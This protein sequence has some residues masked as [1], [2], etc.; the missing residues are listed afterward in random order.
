MPKCFNLTASA[1]GCFRSAF[2]C[3]GLRSTITDLGDGTTIHCWVPKSPKPTKP[4]VVLIHGFGADAVWQWFEAVKILTPHFNVY[5]PDL[6][7]FGESHTTRPDR[8]EAFQAQCVK[9]VMEAKS[10]EKMRLVGMSYG[11]FVAY[12]MA[13][14]FED[15]VEKVVIICS[16]VCLEER[17]I[18]DGMFPVNNVDD[19][20]SILLPQTPEAFRKL[21]R[22][23]FVKPPKPLPSCLINDF[24]QE[25][26]LDF[27]EEKRDL[28]RAIPLD[29]KLAD[30]PKIPQPTLILWGDKDQVFPV[31]L[32]RRLKGHLGENAEL[33]ILEGT[34]HACA[35]EKSKQ[36]GK[37]LKKF[38]LG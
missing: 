18:R 33:I 24:L 1:G 27:V 10:V 4:N 28:L 17:D 20:A 19:A 13:L 2:S 23:T 5:V 31:E 21:L 8:S 22:Y 32:A 26:C 16:P 14:Q 29:K 12:S 30:L 6:V 15:C 11:G 25:M 38:L 3:S 35:F 34:G 9:R 7:F 36:L 37:H